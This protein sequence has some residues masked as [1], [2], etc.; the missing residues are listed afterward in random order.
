MEKL[1][2]CPFCGGGDLELIDCTEHSEG[3]IDYRIR[4]K[5][6]RAYMDSP[7]TTHVE[8]TANGT[9]EARNDETKAKAKRE[10]I[11]NWNRRYGELFGKLKERMR[12]YGISQSELARRLGMSKS[13]MSEKLNG[14]R[15][16]AWKEIKLICDILDIYDPFE[17]FE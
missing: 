1:R 8:A 6:C 11:I 10:L 7:S 13:K 15:E 4:C 9:V 2:E 12:Q 5:T 14:I 17:Y 3:F 16:F